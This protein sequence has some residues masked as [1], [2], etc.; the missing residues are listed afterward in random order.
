MELNL[1]LLGSEYRIWNMRWSNGRNKDDLRF[2]QYLWSK[3]E[4]MKDFTDV[5]NFESA[6]KAYNTL[7][8]DFKTLDK[9][10]IND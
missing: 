5:F 2:G 1:S 9:G 3:Y 8:E 10:Q 7:I 6:E 4:N